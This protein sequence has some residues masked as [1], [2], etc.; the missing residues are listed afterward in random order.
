MLRLYE[1][2]FN[3][4]PKCLLWLS[5]CFSILWNFQSSIDVEG[6]VLHTV[7]L[8]IST[9]LGVFP[10]KIFCWGADH[11]ELRQISQSEI[12]LKKTLRSWK[13]KWWKESVK[14]K[15]WCVLTFKVW[16]KTDYKIKRN[17]YTETEKSDYIKKLAMIKSWS[18]W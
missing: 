4:S 1:K 7:N 12:R 10:C 3:T 8:T 18:N 11:L 17:E 5:C 16:L 9:T 2:Q 15:D 6:K 13:N 14:N